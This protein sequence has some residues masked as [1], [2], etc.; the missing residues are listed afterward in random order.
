MTTGDFRVEDRGTAEA[1]EVKRP[2]IALYKSYVPSMDEG[3]TRWLLEEFGFAYTSVL[4]R[5]LQ[6]DNLR[7]RF[8]VI[9]LP[10]QRADTVHD[11]FK[12]GTMP[13]EYTGGLGEPGAGALRRFV[14]KGGTIICLNEASAYALKYLG[15]EVKDALAGVSS[16]EFYAPGSL[17]NVHLEQHP[18]TLGLSRDVTLWFENGPAFEVTGRER[19]IAVYPENRVLASGWLMGE[20]HIARR[21]AIVDVPVESG[22]VIL[23]GVR[24]QYRAQSYQSFKLFFNALLYF[25]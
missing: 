7:E 4:N 21:A 24:P 3:W 23:F 10:E 6:N 2:R 13:S 19:A 20:K 15:V 11:G 25:E 16:R 22:H 18:L 9:I 5:D 8:D 12:A 17:L 1:Q 14:G